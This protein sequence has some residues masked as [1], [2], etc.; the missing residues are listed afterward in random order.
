M[1]LGRSIQAW[2]RRQRAP[3]RSAG[4]PVRGRG[5]WRV[6]GL[7][8]LDRRLGVGGHAAQGL[9]KPLVKGLVGLTKPM[10]REMFYPAREPLPPS[11]EDQVF[12]NAAACLGMRTT[13]VGRTPEFA[14]SGTGGGSR[15]GLTA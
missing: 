13:R 2:D 15:V 10:Q 14:C 3:P 6:Q 12:G 11:W 7:G 1:W 9:T 4:S 5:W 8:P